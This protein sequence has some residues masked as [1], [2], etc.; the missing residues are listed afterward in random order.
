MW[1]IDYFVRERTVRQSP[2]IV[3]DSCLR[4]FM[5]LCFDFFLGALLVAQAKS[6]LAMQKATDTI[7]QKMQK[8][9]ADV[10]CTYF[11]VVEKSS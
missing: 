2:Y 9:K 11:L 3:D 5:T 6:A 4:F 1:T 10:C 8:H 7:E